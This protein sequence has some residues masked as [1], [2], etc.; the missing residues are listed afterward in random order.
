MSSE[1]PGDRSSVPV[2]PGLRAKREFGRCRLHSWT[3]HRDDTQA[4]LT[5][6]PETG[7][8]VTKL[9]PLSHVLTAK[10]SQCD[11]WLI[12]PFVH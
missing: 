9:P 4:L 10:G 1:A 6:H 8:A 7:M 3:S 2:G 12:Q 5:G 11:K